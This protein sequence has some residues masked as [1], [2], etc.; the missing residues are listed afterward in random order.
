MNGYRKK[1]SISFY[2]CL[3]F[4][5]LTL[6]S[7][8]R[9]GRPISSEQGRRINFELK[10]LRP[11]GPANPNAD[12]GEPRGKA[13]VMRDKETTTINLEIQDMPRNPGKYYVYLI[14]TD[15]EERGYLGQIGIKGTLAYQDPEIRSFWVVVS[16]EADRASVE[17]MIRP[18]SEDVVM[19][20]IAP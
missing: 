12:V 18:D 13:T 6:R 7:Q 3:L 8:D 4:L 17:P 10:Y 15:S 1:L 16:A 9:A 14:R 11:R 20:S 19:I 2:C 5:V